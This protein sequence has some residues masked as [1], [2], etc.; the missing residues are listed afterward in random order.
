VSPLPVPVRE[1]LAL[2]VLLAGLFAGALALAHPWAVGGHSMEPALRPGD[3]VLVDRWTYRHRS[4][5]VGEVVL[6]LGPAA[7]PLVKRVGRSPDG[8]EPSRLWVE[9]DNASASADSRRF[10][11]VAGERVLGRI[12]LRYW[13]PSRV[14]LVR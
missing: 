11:A 5:R 14:G 7:V 12:V 8:Q 13:P 1:V 3:R 6:L 4:P 2:G 9:G 10:G